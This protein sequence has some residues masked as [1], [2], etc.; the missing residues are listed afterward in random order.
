MRPARALH[1]GA[2][3]GGLGRVGGGQAVCTIG[4]LCVLSAKVD[5]CSCAPCRT[6][7]RD[8]PAVAV[9]N[10]SAVVWCQLG[11]P[12]RSQEACCAVAAAVSC[13]HHAACMRVRTVCCIDAMR[14]TA[15]FAS[16]FVC[17][18][19]MQDQRCCVRWGSATHASTNATYIP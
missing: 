6:Y 4:F 5:S 18:T 16:G 17:L 13:L 8:V 15:P 1:L 2:R 7:A 12:S 10:P 11:L 3:Q 14:P 19:S 9:N